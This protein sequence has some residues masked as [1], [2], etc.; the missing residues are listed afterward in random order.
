M[1]QRL[2]N[3]STKVKPVLRVGTLVD[4]FHETPFVSIIVPARNEEDV[5]TACLESL[6]RQ[7][8][9]AHEVIL[10][11]DGSTDKTVELARNV[12]GVHV[13]TARPLLEGWTGK[14]N[15]C[16]SGV[17][18]AK[19]NWLLFTDADT[20]HQPHSFYTALDE[21]KEHLAALVS[22][23]PKQEVRSLAEMLVMPVIF[24]ELA[25]KYPPEK[26]SDTESTVAAANG[27]F[28]MVD[29]EIYRA[30]GGHDSVH[31][32]ILEDVALAKLFKDNGHKIFFRYG[33]DVVRTR[34][35]RTLRQLI[36]GWTKNLILLFPSP[37][38]MVLGKMMQLSLLFGSALF[39]LGSIE[40][41]AQNQ[42][43]FAALIFIATYLAFVLS[44]RKAHFGWGPSLLAPFGNIL[45]LILLLRSYIQRNVYG[46]T[47]WKGRKYTTNENGVQNQFKSKSQPTEGTL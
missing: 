44:V 45:F 4:V 37:L 24:R 43:T 40:S 36:E 8:E 20:V 41:G 31:K 14:N 10:V 22:Y 9:I 18:W 15:A 39:F 27:Q 3:P 1:E 38:H 16:F 35:Y 7:Q 46:R 5:I 33:G 11:D 34:M 32:E 30:L 42:Y 13:I 47:Q 26:V 19:G 29:A 2:P 23:S 21:A 17:L 12:E 6:V 28:L 25:K